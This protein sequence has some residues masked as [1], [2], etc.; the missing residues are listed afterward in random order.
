MIFIGTELLIWNF[1]W[2]N[3]YLKLSGWITAASLLS[4][5]IYSWYKNEY[6]ESKSFYLLHARLSG[7][8][9]PLKEIQKLSLETTLS[10]LGILPD[11]WKKDWDLILSAT[12]CFLILILWVAFIRDPNFLRQDQIFW[13]WLKHLP[14]YFFWAW[15]Q[16]LVLNGYF[17][18][19]MEKILPGRL[20]LVSVI[21]GILFSVV[22]WPNPVLAVATLIGGGLSAYFF[23]RN[24]N[25]YWIAFSHAV[26]A[27]S[28]F[29]FFPDSWHHHLR[30][31]PGFWNF[32]I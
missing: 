32:K 31:G 10:K 16:N 6:L 8:E 27:V 11:R 5:V 21:V 13:K 29:Y 25:L 14:G 22:H 4:L 20:K 17:T 24:K 19:R 30:I 12:L 23:Q 1:D 18:N 26:L 3:S 7:R 28:L 9:I 2:L 15:L